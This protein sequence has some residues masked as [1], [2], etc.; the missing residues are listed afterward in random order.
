MSL[1]VLLR[2]GPGASAE[3]PEYW[4]KGMA[5]T[6]HG[7]QIMFFQT[8]EDLPAG[9]ELLPVQCGWFALCVEPADW[10]EPHV[11]L[12]D[13]PI[14]SRCAAKFGLKAPA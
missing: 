6:M 14:C 1:N 7:P 2:T 11:I 8:G 3:E 13:V 9:G 5:W 10:L 4:G 12:G